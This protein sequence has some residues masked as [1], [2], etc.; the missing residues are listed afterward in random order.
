MTIRGGLFLP[1]IRYHRATEGITG[2]DASPCMAAPMTPP[3]PY[4]GARVV[5]ATRHGKQ[6][7]IGRA[8]RH[9]LGAELVHLADL[10]TDQL[11]SF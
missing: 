7:V 1:G 10:D 2:E 11:G 8:L 9:G 5:L 4:R 6:R 3:H